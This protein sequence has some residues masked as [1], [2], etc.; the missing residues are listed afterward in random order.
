MVFNKQI[1]K[2]NPDRKV[3]VYCYQSDLSIVDDLEIFRLVF[4]S[5]FDEIAA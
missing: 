2:N 3:G 1:F 4:D 5:Y